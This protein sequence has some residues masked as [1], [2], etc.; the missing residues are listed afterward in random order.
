M[1]KVVFVFM[2]MLGF[3]WNCHAQSWTF[4]Q[5]SIATYC[6]TGQSSCTFQPGNMLPTTVGSVWIVSL[7]DGN[8]KPTISSVTGGGGT[9]IHCTACFVSDATTGHQIDVWYNLTGTA[10]TTT[11]VKLNYSGTISSGPVSALFTEI[12]PPAGHSAFYDTAATAVNPSCT[13]CTGA[14][15]QLAATD[16]VVQISAGF[17]PSGWNACSAPYETDYA[18]NC[19]GLNLGGA[20]VAPKIT[21]LGGGAI[22]SAIAFQSTLGVF[23]PITPV[24][25]AVQFANPNGLNC[26]PSC[27]MSFSPLHSGDLL[28][29]QAGNSGSAT[30]SSISGGAGSWVIPSGASTCQI[31]L[32]L[33][34]E[35]S[36]AYALSS[37]SGNITVTM[38]GSVN[39]SFA[40]WEVSTT[41]TGFQLDTQGSASDSAS[42]SPAG[43]TLTLNSTGTPDAIFQSIFVYG[44]SSSA[45]LYPM[46]YIPGW[47]NEFFHGQASTGLLLNTRN[48]AAPNWADQ[49]NNATAV[50]AVAF[51]TGAGAVLPAPPTNLKAVAN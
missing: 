45:T 22:F 3:A 34:Y 11:G 19:I 8:G 6:T 27:S 51:T 29:I 21:S 7:N 28:Y 31:H 15:V 24:F 23:T 12:L 33:G 1:K 10:G 20:I 39:T 16:A 49:Q 2:L 18:S 35:L 4:V 43:V 50:T 25:S 17:S 44:G 41:G 26:S 46:P 40:V 32:S 36:C 14:P 48:G 5:D 9:W 13:S 30:I 38:S 47:G 42:Y 37:T